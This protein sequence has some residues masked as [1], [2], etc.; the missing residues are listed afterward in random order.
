[1]NLP[2]NT[3]SNKNVSLNIENEDLNNISLFSNNASF[4]HNISDI[5]IYNIDKKGDEYQKTTNNK[6]D[7][8]C[9]A[10][11]SLTEKI[12][13][14]VYQVFAQHNL[15]TIKSIGGWAKWKKLSMT[16]WAFDHLDDPIDSQDPSEYSK[17]YMEAIM[18]KVF[19]NESPSN[20]S[21]AYIMA[22]IYLFLDP[23]SG[24][25]EMNERIV[26]PKMIIYLDELN[27]NVEDSN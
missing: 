21:T 18:E 26:I 9:Y 1:K 23:H 22:V 19:P 20:N 6:E 14:A 27:E 8:Y 7:Q 16:E 10:R 4:I 25:V 3:E 2:L 17:T 24:I 11:G 12:K 5:D 13:N 15:P